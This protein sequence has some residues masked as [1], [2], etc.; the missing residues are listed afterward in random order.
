MKTILVKCPD[1]F[2]D[3]IETCHNPDHGF[4]SQCL[5][6]VVGANES[7]CPCCVHSQDYKMR[8]YNMKTGKY[9]NNICETCSGSGKIS[10]GL[11]MDFLDENIP[12]DD[13]D[14][15]NEICLTDNSKPIK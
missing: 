11:Y 10:M 2:G 14:E 13:Q 5:G 9:E 15:V 6:P 7:A 1:C 3:G 4:L 12:H 8:N